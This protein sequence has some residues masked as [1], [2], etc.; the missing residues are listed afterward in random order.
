MSLFPSF[1]HS[2]DAAHTVYTLVVMCGW[3]W[4]CVVLQ[5]RALIK[6]LLA[7]NPAERP[8]ISQTL[9]QLNQ[10]A[11]AI[12]GKPLTPPSGSIAPG[13]PAS[14]TTAVSGVAPP[15]AAQQAAQQQLQQLP[16][17]LLQQQPAAAAVSGGAFWGTVDALVNKQQQHAA[18]ATAGDGA[19]ALPQQQQQ[20]QLTPDWVR[21]SSAGAAAQQPAAVQH[22][23]QAQAGTPGSPAHRA[24]AVAVPVPQAA[25]AAGSGSGSAAG[26]PPLWEGS[27]AAAAA[28][29]PT[30]SN[31]YY[32]SIILAH[33]SG[34]S[35]SLAGQQQG[36]PGLGRLADITARAQA[37]AA[38]KTSQAAAAVAPQQQQN[39]EPPL[40]LERQPRPHYSSG[41]SASS[42]EATP[43]LAAAAATATAGAVRPR[44]TPAAQGSAAGGPS[45]SA[46]V[47][48]A[49]TSNRSVQET[50]GSAGSNT[51]SRAAAAAGPSSSQ[52]GA[53][54]VGAAMAGMAAGG[55]AATSTAFSGS[56]THPLP[57]NTAM[58]G[59]LTAAATNPGA[60]AGAAAAQPHAVD[61]S[62]LADLRAAV[63]GEMNLLRAQVRSLS[64]QNQ[65]F[66]FRIKQLE[67]Y[68]QRQETAVA[69]L[70]EQVAALQQQQV[71]G[72]SLVRDGLVGSSRPA[73]MQRRSSDTGPAGHTATV[74][75]SYWSTESAAN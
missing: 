12:L 33:S 72:S 40:V 58:V 70:Q 36:S 67:G 31:G 23:Q 35:S 1:C 25:A 50:S 2:P 41:S 57:S 51:S 21:F 46:N 39:D 63:F 68:A 32:P 43:G 45:I 60:P 14:S 69:K 27:G 30:T 10:A 26:T 52:Y 61:A 18:A 38:A 15:P 37:A 66:V 6:R 73:A 16:Q 29:A 28:S 55:G 62:V 49:A 5:L 75:G 24:Q 42:T 9:E 64:D 11:L 44:L 19:H 22:V 17:P 53:Q 71:D 74:G 56:N 7:I 3:C 8:D 34:S 13:L 54:S 59:P 20:Q 65:A 47:M 4:R 48:Q